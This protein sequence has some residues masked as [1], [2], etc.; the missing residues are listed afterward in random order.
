[1]PGL[2]SGYVGAK[3]RFWPRA[4]PDAS[5]TEGQD[6][7]IRNRMWGRMRHAHRGIPQVSCGQRDW[8]ATSGSPDREARACRGAVRQAELLIDCEEDRTLPTVLVD[9]LREADRPR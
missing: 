3:P 9:M 7:G 1:L 4:D 8:D 2:G 6:G 5:R